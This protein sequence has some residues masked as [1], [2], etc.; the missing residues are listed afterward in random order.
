MSVFSKSSVFRDNQQPM[1]KRRKQQ[2][3]RPTKLMLRNRRP[4][5]RKKRRRQQRRQHNKKLLRRLRFQ[6]SLS[7]KP[8]RKL[9]LQ[10]LLR[11]D[12]NSKVAHARMD[13]IFRLQQR[14]RPIVRRARKWTKM[15][16]TAEYAHRLE[17]LPC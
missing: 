1:L 6:R 15:L 14:F 11:R 16:W 4:I 2:S 9:R 17:F 5:K 3:V 7:M 12:S 10:M 13:Q 8:L